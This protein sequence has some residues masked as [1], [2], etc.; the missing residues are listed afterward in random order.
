MEAMVHNLM[1]RLYIARKDRDA[2][3]AAFNTA[4]A[5]NQNLMQ[6]YYTLAQIYLG[7][8]SPD[9]AIEQLNRLLEVNSRQVGPHMLLGIVYDAQGK[10][11]L[12]ETHY[13]KAL[14]I[15]PEFA[16]AANNLAFLLAEQ[17]K[18]IDE[19]LKW[20]RLAK[21]KLPEDPNV[22]DTLGWVYYR[23]GLLDSAV[24]EFKDSL[25]KKPDNPAVIYHLGMAYLE[26][27]DRE[28][29]REEISRALKMSDNFIGSAEARRALAELK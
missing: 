15:N 1:G 5:K 4:I 20:A 22:M 8:N 14:G 3:E 27:E 26:K 9:K 6:P 10:Y 17:N 25:E 23:K 18:D 16:P 13:R 28:K 12:S 2:A 7:E 21:E 11:D 24:G 29:A 19:A